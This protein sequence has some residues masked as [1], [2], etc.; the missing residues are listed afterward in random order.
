MTNPIFNRTLL[1]IHRDNASTHI[2]QHDFLLKLSSNQLFEHAISLRSSYNK[3]L[4]LGARSGILTQKL[5]EQ[6]PSSY[7]LSTDISEEML[8]ANPAKHKMILDEENIP[9]DLIDF[10][11]VTSVLNTH[12]INDL[13][14]FFKN[15]KTMLNP[16]G[17]LVLSLFGAPTLKNLRSLLLE[18]EIETESIHSPHISP[19]VNASDL[20]KILQ[21][22][23]F[24]FIIVEN[25]TVETEYDNPIALMRELNHMGES[26][27]LFTAHPIMP[28][29]L[30]NKL[31][32]IQ[33]SC[34]DSFEIITLVAS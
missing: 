21:Y 10:D 34:N 15:I 13:P 9:K 25:D 4:D 32:S 7:I 22:A 20:Y 14:Q 33:E 27:N 23:G 30:W 5:I 12:W 29:K 1:K 28:K 31:L 17:V 19:F 3:I 8:T 6:Y 24:S 26:N 16:D 2:N 11:L 18:A